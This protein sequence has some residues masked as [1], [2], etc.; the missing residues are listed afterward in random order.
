[1]QTDTISAPQHNKRKTRKWI[2]GIYAVSLAL[3]IGIWLYSYLFG[4]LVLDLSFSV[5]FI[6]S[7]IVLGFNVLLW[8][9]FEKNEDELVYANELTKMQLVERNAAN[10]ATAITG[11]LLVAA[12]L[13]AMKGNEPIPRQVITYQSVALILSVGG[14]LPKIWIPSRIVE[15]L[16]IL[17]HIKTILLTFA[18]AL[19]LIGLLDLLHWN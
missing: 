16:L 5:P 15:W 9:R 19:F 6:L 18:I 4:T 3:W 7:L 12:A 8:S 11:V 2:L 1:M 13:S 10:I 17:R 14:V